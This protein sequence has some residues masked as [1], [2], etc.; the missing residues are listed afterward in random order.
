MEA[1]GQN[2][3]VGGNFIHF[4][5]KNLISGASSISHVGSSISHDG[6]FVKIVLKLWLR[7]GVFLCG[8]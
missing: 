8:G 6:S 1:D 7:L 3:K 4:C 5:A 2:I